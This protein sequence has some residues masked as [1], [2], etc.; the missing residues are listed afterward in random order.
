MAARLQIAAT[1]W[2]LIASALAHFSTCT[3]GAHA[4]PA[5]PRRAHKAPELAE[6][7]DLQTGEYRGQARLSAR[8]KVPIGD[9]FLVT[10]RFKN[11]SGH[12]YDI[13]NPSLNS[14][15]R[16]PAV[17]AIFDAEGRYIGDLSEG[18]GSS[19]RL[20]LEFG[21]WC[22]IDAGEERE[23][24]LS[25]MAGVVRKTRY[26]YPEV[27]LPPGKYYLQA[28]YFDFFASSCPWHRPANP[29]GRLN[30]VLDRDG[31]IQLP[32]K[33]VG[34]LRRTHPEVIAKA[35]EDWRSKYDGSVLFRSNVVEIEFL[36]PPAEAPRPR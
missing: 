24:T 15:I 9:E 29:C 20:G 18:A 13:F 19:V 16:R 14:L 10:L 3:P 1:R 22:R 32:P 11:T 7:K 4:E 12:A 5:S 2:A 33:A 25:C 27:G 6:Q 26:L 28:I 17:V 23:V 31:E 35:E 8:E 21:D 30:G 36:P 34:D